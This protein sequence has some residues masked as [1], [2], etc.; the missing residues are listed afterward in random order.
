VPA[1]GGRLTVLSCGRGVPELGATSWFGN[2]SGPGGAGFGGWGSEGGGPNPDAVAAVVDA[3][4]RAGDTVVCDLPRH[5]PDAAVTAVERAE[6]VVL[7]VPAE[8]R[9]CAAALPVVERLRALGAQVRLVVRGPSPGGLLPVDV[10]RALALPL[11][12]AM[13]A[14]PGLAA[15]LDAGRLP[16]RTPRNPLAR[17]AAV[18]LDMVGRDAP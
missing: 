5:L 2:G 6:L 8:V 3:G 10:S 9:A 15:A 11:L 17:A 16:V 1:D 4:R 7:V 18:V 14:A 12:V 13:R